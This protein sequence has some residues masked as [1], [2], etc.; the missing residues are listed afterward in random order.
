MEQVV[1]VVRMRFWWLVTLAYLAA[2][3]YMSAQSGDEIYLTVPDY[4]L[5]A[6]EYGGLSFC[7]YKA[8]K[9][10]WPH[11]SHHLVVV[12]LATFYGLTDELHQ[13]FVPGR[14]PSFSDIIADFTG[15]TLMQLCLWGHSRLVQ[16]RNSNLIKRKR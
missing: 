16:E 15:A 3:F 2:I 1:K 13:M 14:D 4:I 7:L 6:I 8:L 11:R 9:S 10:T 5:H 12:V